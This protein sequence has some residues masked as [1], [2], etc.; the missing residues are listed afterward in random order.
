MPEG[1]LPVG[2]CRLAPLDFVDTNNL[3]HYQVVDEGNEAELQ[4]V[5]Q[6]ISHD[7]LLE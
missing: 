1:S 7:L 2:I 4:Q 6:E 3:S 5:G